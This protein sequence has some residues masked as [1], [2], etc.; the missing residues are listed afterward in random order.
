MT[1]GHKHLGAQ[2]ELVAAAWLIGQGF[3]VFRNVSPHGDIDLIAVRGDELRKFDV[4]TARRRV[5]QDDRERI[6][7]GPKA[8]PGVERLF[9]VPETGEVLMEFPEAGKTAYGA[10]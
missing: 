1:A 2:S 5:T 6:N 9:V 8:A 3:D 4:K 10:R 7:L